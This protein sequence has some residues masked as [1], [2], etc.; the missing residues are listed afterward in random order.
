MVGVIICFEGWFPES[1]RE[2]MLKG[3]QIICHSVLTCQE[4]TLDIMRVRAI[5]NKAFIIVS[6][7][8]STENHNDETVTF[9]GDS[10]VIDYNGEIL[11]NAGKEEKLISVE[12]NEVST[13]NKDLEDCKDLVYEVKKHKYF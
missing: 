7:S 9:R 10:R 8:T 12:I 11:V 5:E 1:S 13:I 2:L 3:A 6:N 4:R